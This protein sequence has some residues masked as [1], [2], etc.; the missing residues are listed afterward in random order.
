MKASLRYSLALGASMALALA[1]AAAVAQNSEAGSQGQGDQPQRTI[2]MV[3]AR[4]QLSK[5]IDAKKAKQG[6]PVTA[7]LSDKV[8]IPDAQELPKDTVL[9]GH[10]D[11]VQPSEHKSDSTVVVTFDKAKLKDGKELPIK[12]TVVS[13]SEPVNQFQQTQGGAPAG[14]PGMMPSAQ[15]GNAP[16]GSPGGGA[17]TGPGAAAPAP[18]PTTMPQEGGAGA[19]QQ[20]QQQGQKGVPGVMLTSDIHQHTSATFTSKGKNVKVPDG[21]QLDVALTIVPAGVNIQ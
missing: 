16:G 10:I 9:E 19:E 5:T 4:A 1:A 7:K 3:Q 12:A 18:P 6:E 2:Q 11:Q 21:T 13:I 8:Q 17:G 14:G 15:P 20:A